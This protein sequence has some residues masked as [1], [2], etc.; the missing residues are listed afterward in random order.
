[1]KKPCEEVSLLPFGDLKVLAL[2]VGIPCT[3]YF[4]E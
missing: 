2:L 1:M 4:I 3:N